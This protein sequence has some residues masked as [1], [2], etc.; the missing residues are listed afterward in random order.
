MVELKNENEDIIVQP[1][2]IETLHSFFSI[3]IKND[4]DLVI[5]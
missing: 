2:N 3:K 5:V 1:K 4:A